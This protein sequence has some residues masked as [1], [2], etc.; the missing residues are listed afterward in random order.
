MRGLKSIG[1]M[2]TAA[3][4]V[5]GLGSP[6]AADP[7]ADQSFRVLYAGSFSDA[8][9]GGPDGRSVVTHGVVNSV[10]YETVLSEG[11]G[12]TPGSFVATT[13][14]TFPDGSYTVSLSIVVEGTRFFGPGDCHVTIDISGTYDLVGASGVFT[15]MTG[16][17][18]VSGQNIVFAT[19]TDD[20]CSLEG[21]RL[22]SNLDGTGPVTSGGSAG[23]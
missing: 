13:Q 3:V 8:G 17:G 5:V 9:E 2:V 18:T 12:P 7:E 1:G 23:A 20:G 19:P 21:A 6:A 22:V 16:T 10:G 4:I 15:G 11:P 14:F